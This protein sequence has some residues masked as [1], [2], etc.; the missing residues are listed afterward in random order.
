MTKKDPRTAPH[1][2]G[3]SMPAEILISH[4]AYGGEPGRVTEYV[5]ADCAASKEG[6]ARLSRIAALAA[7]GQSITVREAVE[8]LAEIYTEARAGLAQDA[9]PRA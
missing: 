4:E 8:I 2:P 3:I 1:T 6:K 7:P 9:A 5:R